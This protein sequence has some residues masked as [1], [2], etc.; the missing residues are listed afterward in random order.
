MHCGEC[1]APIRAQVN[2]KSAHGAISIQILD[3]ES[4]KVATMQCGECFA[5]IR[6][7]V[8][9]KSVHGVISGAKHS[10]PSG[11]YAKSLDTRSRVEIL[12]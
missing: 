10:P 2:W 7:Q 8:N 1:F 3:T 9:W 5:P 11:Q 4:F 12:T 6:A